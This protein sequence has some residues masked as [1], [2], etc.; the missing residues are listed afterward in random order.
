MINRSI[1]IHCVNSSK[2]P[3]LY[4]SGYRV[5]DESDDS[6]FDSGLIA[7]PFMNMPDDEE[8]GIFC[9]IVIR[10]VPE[11]CRYLTEQT[12]SLEG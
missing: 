3:S 7:C 4:S 1:C 9:E 2:S 5:W 11:G 6:R 12:V 10:K 8:N